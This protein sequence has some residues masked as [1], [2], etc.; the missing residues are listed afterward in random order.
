MFQGLRIQFAALFIDGMINPEGFGN[1]RGLFVKKSIK[2][3][4]DV[5]DKLLIK[6]YILYK[7]PFL[8]HTDMLENYLIIAQYG[9]LNCNHKMKTHIIFISDCGAQNHGCFMTN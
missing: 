1:L 7:W 8:P 5:P 4:A 2:N 3:R 9:K 6:C